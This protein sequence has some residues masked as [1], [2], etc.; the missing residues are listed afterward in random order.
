MLENPEV[1]AWASCQ[2]DTTTSSELVSAG[3]WHWTV[4]ESSW[5]AEGRERCSMGWWGQWKCMKWGGV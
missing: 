2:Q 4:G 5:E 3:G 1:G